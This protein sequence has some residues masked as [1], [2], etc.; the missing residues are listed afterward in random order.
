MLQLM[1]SQYV[2]VLSLLWDLWPDITSCPRIV[3]LS[4]SD[5]S[6][7]MSGLLFCSLSL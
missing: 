1:V 2:V 3:A 7:E 4:L 6:Y 5:A